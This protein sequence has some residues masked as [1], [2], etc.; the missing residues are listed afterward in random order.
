M[1][2]FHY[3]SLYILK[4]KSEHIGL[5]E[6]N[7]KPKCELLFNVGKNKSVRCLY[8]DISKAFPLEIWEGIFPH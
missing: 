6:I 3:F 7:V 1:R 4:G 5:G 2:D 8:L